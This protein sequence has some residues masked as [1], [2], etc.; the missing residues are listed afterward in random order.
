MDSSQGNPTYTT[1]SLSKE[2]IIDN[3]MPVLS[4]FGLSAYF[5][6]YLL[7][8]NVAKRNI[9]F[10]A[11]TI[12]DILYCDGDGHTGFKMNS[13]TVSTTVVSKWYGVSNTI[14]RLCCHLKEIVQYDKI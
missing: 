4:Y 6:F 13:F 5:T 10:I 8:N 2:E 11:L 14:G 12:T 1:T 7:Q 9:Y 3:H